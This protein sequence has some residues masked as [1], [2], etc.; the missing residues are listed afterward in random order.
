MNHPNQPNNASVILDAARLLEQ[1]ARALRR[2]VSG[3]EYAVN[4]ARLVRLAKT[5]V[6]AA[7][8]RIDGLSDRPE[9]YR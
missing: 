2:V 9:D 6:D 7:T 8:V 3:D 4:C 1:A 5:A